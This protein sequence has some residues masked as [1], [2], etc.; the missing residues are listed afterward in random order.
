ML[1]FLSYV[2]HRSIFL[3]DESL[4]SFKKRQKKTM[5]FAPAGFPPPPFGGAT[6]VS[7]LAYDGAAL[8]PPQCATGSDTV[9]SNAGPSAWDM[10]DPPSIG[11][12]LR[13]FRMNGLFCDVALHFTVQPWGEGTATAA[14]N[15]SPGGP[16]PPPLFAHKVVLAACSPYFFAGK[17][18]SV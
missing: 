6:R 1:T 16:T 17:W 10:P 15:D 2:T 14:A 12:A 11:R 8:F 13:N 3:Q 4:A 9:A 18:S 5:A 7:D